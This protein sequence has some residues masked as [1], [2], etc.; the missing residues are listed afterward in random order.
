[1]ASGDHARASWRDRLRGGDDVDLIDV[2][3]P[4]EWDIAQNPR[5]AARSARHAR[6]RR[7]AEFDDTRDVVVHCKSGR[8]QRAGGAATAAPRD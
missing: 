2:R 6:R 5:R 4:H 7:M 1:M 3:E 8:A